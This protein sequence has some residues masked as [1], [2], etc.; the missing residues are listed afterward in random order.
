ME[1]RDL[2]YV[3]AVEAHG[4][5]GRAA[6]ALDMT[7]PA[8]TKAVQ[9][10]EAQLGVP[11][12]ERTTLGMRVTQAGTVFLER[13]RRI[14][15]EYEDAIKEMRGIQTGEQ[16]MLRLGYSPSMPNA[17]VLG[18]CRQLIRERPVA[19]LRL[20]MRVAR[21]LMDLLQAGEL[22]L[23]IAPLPRQAN[24]ALVSRELFTDRLAVVADE[25]HPLL[26]RRNLTL[27]DLTDQQW[28][29]PS[30]HVLI[31]QQIDA[32]FTELGLPAPILR[33]E[34][35]FGSTALFDL[36]RGTEMLCIAGSTSNGA[37]AGLRPI[38]LRPDAL[39]LG[40]RVGVMSRAGAYLSPLA[41]RMIG[42]FEARM[43]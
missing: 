4:G 1:T 43:Q 24:P 17:L 31:R 8:L 29:L 23:A 18:A 5:I 14:R 2:E 15:L 42:I 39:D 9:R 19:R 28:L 41:L 6:E 37:Q 25:N 40:R 34:T 13:A 12:F 11:L 35:D 32:A 16:G 21:E 10:V 30:S 20:T 3:L 22:D 26:R 7:Q 38:A 27:A 33:V 36:V